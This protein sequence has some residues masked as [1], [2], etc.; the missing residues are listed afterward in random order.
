MS[1][2][3]IVRIEAGQPAHVSTFKRIADAL[4]VE[5]TEIREFREMVEN[6]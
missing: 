1:T 6:A 2:R 4:G 3:T 5:M